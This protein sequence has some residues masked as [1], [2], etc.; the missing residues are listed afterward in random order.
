MSNIAASMQVIN[1]ILNTGRMNVIEQYGL[2]EEHIIDPTARNIY[3]K[4]KDYY[5][6][7]E[8]IPKREALLA[9]LT[10]E[11][12]EFLQLATSPD[13]LADSELRDL[14]WEDYTFH[15]ASSLIQR[16][17]EIME[18]DAVEAVSYLKSHLEPLQ[19]TVGSIG[20]DI[21]GNAMKRLE[22]Y[23]EKQSTDDWFYPSGFDKLDEHIGGFSPGEDLIVLF[24]RTGVGKEQPLYSKV[25]T[26]DGYINM[27]DV[28]LGQRVIT[29]NGNIAKVVA[30]FPQGVKPVYELRFNDGS[31]VRAGLEHLWEAHRVRFG[32]V[33]SKY[34]ELV[35][36]EQLLAN[37]HKWVIPVVKPFD[38]VDENN[39]F[40]NDCQFLC[41]LMCSYDSYVMIDKDV[42]K[43]Y[44]RGE[45]SQLNKIIKYTINIGGYICPIDSSEIEI[46][47]PLS[48]SLSNIIHKTLTSDS[49]VDKLSLSNILQHTSYFNRC[50]SVEVIQDIRLNKNLTRSLFTRLDH[51]KLIDIWNN[52][53][54]DNVDAF[55]QLIR[56]VG[57]IAHYDDTIHSI[58]CKSGNKLYRR[59]NEV[60]YVEDSECQCLMVDDPSHTYITDNYTV[61]HNTW[62]LTKMLY[63]SWRSG[64]NVGLVE[65]EMTS[66]KIGYRFDTIHKHYSNKDLMYGRKI[67]RG[68]SD[69]DKFQEYDK[70]IADLSKSSTATFKVAHPKEF[71]GEITVSKIKQWCIA[72]NIKILGIDGI[73]YIKDE[74][75]LP[76]DNTTT[77]LTHISADLMELSIQLKIPVLIVV[78]SNREGTA[79][80][81]R[82]ALENIR[83]S[84]GIAYSA[85]KVLGLYKKQDA[86]HVELLKNRDAESGLCLV[87]DWDINTGKFS[88]L[89]EG[90]LDGDT[91]D[92]TDRSTHSYSPNSNNNENNNSSRPS[93]VPE[94]SRMSPDNEYAF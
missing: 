26:P 25:L 22:V 48:N 81:G 49:H 53:S 7:H 35:T 84:D 31:K 8:E 79:N 32:R 20:E 89:Q 78:Q 13:T 73:S 47:I 82:L 34:S 80:G 60:V 90:A 6:R 23:N 63:T 93:R 56:S 39:L 45:L 19:R 71:T 57:L 14:I 46:R 33:V 64:Y 12:S 86:L 87:Y 2:S 5:D 74:R 28:K 38:I 1:R 92:N 18:K 68:P 54:R 15:K 58:V 16:S 91:S 76:G 66:T 50:K 43:I 36:I 65:P 59:I 27:G 29:M 41:S 77:A 72:E 11:E 3:K 61:T 4:I 83:D 10:P 70:Y 75:S 88:F 37:P 69:N 62:I 40:V 85:S 52:N 42:L 30:I 9:L 44:V 51:I 17:A 55:L 21:I 94:N 67:D 24:A